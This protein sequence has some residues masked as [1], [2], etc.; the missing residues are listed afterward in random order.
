MSELRDIIDKHAIKYRGLFEERGIE[1]N[2]M[3][4]LSD[5]AIDKILALVEGELPNSI[6]GTLP[7]DYC[8]GYNQALSDIQSVLD[9]LKSKQEAN[10]GKREDR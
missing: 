7:D 2:A 1:E 4:E 9:G 3:D 5:E 8:R 10:N 6:G